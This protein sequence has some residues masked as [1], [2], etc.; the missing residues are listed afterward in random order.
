MF[1]VKV[2]VTDW[3]IALFP[4]GHY[5]PRYCPDVVFALRVSFFVVNDSCILTLSVLA[6]EFFYVRLFIV[7]VF[8]PLSD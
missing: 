5:M 4:G 3:V 8:V 6:R 7:S 2:G 1:V